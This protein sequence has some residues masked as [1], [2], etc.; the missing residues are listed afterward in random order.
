MK[1][2]N[3]IQYFLSLSF[4]YIL[5]ELIFEKFRIYYEFPWLDNPMHIMG[6]FF[7]SGLIIN[8][9]NILFKDK[10]DLNFRINFFIF[11]ICILAIS[12]DWE[13]YGYIMDKFSIGI[14]QG[15]LI[16]SSK[17]IVN[18]FIGAFIYILLFKDKKNQNNDKN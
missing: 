5:S 17:D 10:F 16:D 4:L 13:L 1:Y 9:L 12:I 11:L 18:N 8:I 2:K 15:N 7:I 3:L 14:W 6:G